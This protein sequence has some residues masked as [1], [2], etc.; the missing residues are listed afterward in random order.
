MKDLDLS[1]TELKN[2]LKGSEFLI[3]EALCEKLQTNE[4]SKPVKRVTI[5]PNTPETTE[6]SPERISPGKLDEPSVS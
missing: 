6:I 2:A 4:S 3:I 5:S 1:E